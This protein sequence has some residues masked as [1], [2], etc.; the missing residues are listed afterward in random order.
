LKEITE[1]NYW[2]IIC[3]AMPGYNSKICHVQYFFKRSFSLHIS[4]WY[5]FLTS[6]RK[7]LLCLLRSHNP[8]CS[9][10]TLCHFTLSTPCPAWGTEKEL[11]TKLIE[12]ITELNF[13][14]LNLHHTMLR[15]SSKICH[16]Q[17][18]YNSGNNINTEASCIYDRS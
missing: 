15:Y 7:C 10:V 16:V 8:P 13:C 17:Y 9:S 6:K 1:L 2:T 18:F 5:S 14:T 4:I 11:T 3:S 12:K